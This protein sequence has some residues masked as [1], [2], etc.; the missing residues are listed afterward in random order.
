M[1]RNKKYSPKFKKNLQFLNLCD[2]EFML[3]NHLK[4]E[5]KGKELHDINYV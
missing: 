4:S 5:L 1:K 3:Y 2:V